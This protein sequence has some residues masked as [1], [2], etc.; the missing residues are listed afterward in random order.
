MHPLFWGVMS[1]ATVAGGITAYPI[2]SWM[3]ARGVKHGMMSAPEAKP[4]MKDMAGMPAMAMPA[5]QDPSLA[6]S[7]QI[8]VIGLT[9]LLLA[10]AI[11]ADHARG[12]HSLDRDRLTIPRGVRIIAARRGDLA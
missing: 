7:R 6:V 3:V 8:A 11:V 10:L 4:A 9:S 2:N 1:V 5:H 12:A